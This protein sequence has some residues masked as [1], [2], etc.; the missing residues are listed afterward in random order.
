MI[1]MRFFQAGSKMLGLAHEN[2]ADVVN[3]INESDVSNK[4]VINVETVMEGKKFKGL[5]VWYK[6]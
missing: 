5:R 6:N 3:R 2:I 4:Q 1:A